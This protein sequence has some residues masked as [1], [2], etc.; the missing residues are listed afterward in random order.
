[1]E[2]AKRLDAMRS[3]LQS[4]TAIGVVASIVF[5]RAKLHPNSVKSAGELL[6]NT[7]IALCIAE[8]TLLFGLV[9][10]AKLH[11]GQF[12]VTSALVLIVDFGFILPAS[13]RLMTQPNSEN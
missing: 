1:M 7:F 8:V 5:T 6:R 4:V 2:A 3:A 12:L 9:G 10:L 11:F 13:L